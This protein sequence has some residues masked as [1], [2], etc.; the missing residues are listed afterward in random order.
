MVVGR[1]GTWATKKAD[2][3]RACRPTGKPQGFAAAQS[4]V[5]PSGGRQN[6]R[7]SEPQNLR[8]SEPQNLRT[9]EQ[10]GTVTPPLRVL[11]VEDDGP[12]Q[13]YATNVLK[14][15]GLLVDVVTNGADAIDALSTVEYSLVVMDCVMPV[16]DGIEATKRI[17][18]GST[19]AINPSIPIIGYTAH[20]MPENMKALNCAG[21]D[22]CITKPSSLAIF[23]AFIEKW[24]PARVPTA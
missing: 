2:A 17:R 21:M 3:A 23:T 10:G 19:N 1:R 4:G 18:A 9:S 12:S 7:T 8:T 15:L 5:F 13:A 20:V 24:L 14:R 16:M 11:L 6:L 22:D